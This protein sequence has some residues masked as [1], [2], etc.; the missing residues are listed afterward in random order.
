VIRRVK[1]LFKGNRSLILGFNQFLPPGYKIEIN[2]PPPAAERR[3]TIEFKQAMEYVAKIKNRFREEPYIYAE[4]LDILHDY[5]AK[6]TIDEVYQRV[7]KLF[8]GQPDLL[9]EFKYFLPESAVAPKAGGAGRGAQSKPVAGK[10]AAGASKAGPGASKPGA[11]KAVPGSKQTHDA[12]GRPYPLKPGQSKPGVPA[13][14]LDNRGGSSAGGVQR[15]S[16]GNIIPSSKDALAK[17]PSTSA[18]GAAGTSAHHGSSSHKK[19]GDHR[20]HRHHHGSS[21]HAARVSYPPGSE[22]ELSLLERMKSLSTKAQWIQFLKALNLFANDLVNRGELIRMVEDVYGERASGIGA[23]GVLSS[24]SSAGDIVE[25]FKQTI[26]YDE[27]EEKAVASLN[28]TNYYAFVSSV[29][30]TICPQVTP[31]YRELPPQ[32]LVPHSTGRSALA[33]E[34]RNDTCTASCG[35]IARIAQ[36]EMS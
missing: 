21:S 8:K 36:T 26:G 29:D 22:K 31:S 1:S 13:G 19:H 7:Q 25:R 15:D 16:R 27:A 17:K 10:S 35:C 18:G 14:K 11:A 33:D 28:Q 23:G 12:Q 4:F 30:F 34:V 2:E 6:R 20:E 32:I 9:D 3:P 24:L 5:Q